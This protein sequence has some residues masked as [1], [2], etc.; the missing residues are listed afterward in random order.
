MIKRLEAFIAS[1]YLRS[2]RKEVFISIITVISV[3]GVAISVLVL[4]TTL[5]VM[6]GFESE[7]QLKL[8]DAN[9]HIFIRK[10]GSNIK[11]WPEVLNKVAKIEGIVSAQPYTYSQAMISSAGGSHGLIIR[12]VADLPSA[13]ARFERLMKR[14]GSSELLFSPSTYTVTRPDGTQDDVVLPPLIVGQALRTRLGLEENEPVTLLAPSFS[15]TPQGLAPKLRRFLVVGTYRSGLSEYESGIAYTSM[16]EA[17]R[18]FG[19]ED[20]VTGIEIMVQ[21][22]FKAGAIAAKVSEALGGIEAPYIVTDWTEP[23]KALWEAMQLEKRVYFIVLLLL[24]LVASFS[25]ISTL[26]MMVMEKSKDIAILKSLGAS[27]QMV[28]RIFLLQGIIIGLVGT[29]L[30]TLLGYL[31]CLALKEFGFPINPAVFS[32]DKVPV[33][34]VPENFMVVAFAAFIITSF[35]GVYPA[36]RAAKINPAEILRYE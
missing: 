16:P 27:D 35:A 2:K 34:I 26:V 9:A 14:T 15:A 28:L 33:Y 11:E 20:S 24:I 18:F 6:T 1:R 17:Q 36:L 7:L 12:G 10:F 8:L 13:R 4:N 31:S 5:A 3:L 21:D 29:L 32:L 30:G 23:N 19:L 22:M 25:I